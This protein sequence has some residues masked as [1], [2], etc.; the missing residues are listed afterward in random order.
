MPTR[1]IYRL[2]FPPT[3]SPGVTSSVDTR[4]DS[5]LFPFVFNCELSLGLTVG[6][7]FISIN[8]RFDLR[9]RFVVTRDFRCGWKG[10]V[11]IV[12]KA[13][14]DARGEIRPVV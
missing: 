1:G 11:G 2:C 8:T 6:Q 10:S 5:A 12:K 4:K 13:Q 14:G 9:D 7:C 3:S